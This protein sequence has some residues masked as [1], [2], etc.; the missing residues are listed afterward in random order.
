MPCHIPCY[1]ILNSLGGQIVESI[2]WFINSLFCYI[3]SKKSTGSWNH[4]YLF[5]PY[6]TN[7]KQHQKITE[8]FNVTLIFNLKCI[9]NVSAT[10]VDSTLS[11][12]IESLSG[13]G[14]KRFIPHP[15]SNALLEAAHHSMLSAHSIGFRFSCL[16]REICPHLVVILLQSEPNL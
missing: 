16:L 13:C 12:N 14:I 1:I 9:L 10:N 11:R 5:D 3:H 4:W 7:H 15:S 8:S 6:V 2:Y